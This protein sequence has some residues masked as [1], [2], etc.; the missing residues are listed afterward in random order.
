MPPDTKHLV[1][2]WNPGDSFEPATIAA[3]ADILVKFPTDRPHVWW[4]KLSKTGRLGI[5][6]ADVLAIQEQIR[7]GE[8]THLYLY[9]P[10]RAKPCVHVGKLEWVQEGNPGEP[11][12]VPTYYSRLA[13]PIPFW[14]R[15]SDIRELTT[16]HL[17]YLQTSPGR[18]Y[19]P[20]AANAYPLVVNS[21]ASTVLFDYSHPGATKWHLLQRLHQPTG[22][23]GDIDP[24]LVFVLMPFDPVFTDVWHLGIKSTVEKLGLTCKRANEFLHSRDIMEEIRENIR[25]SRLIIADMTTSN[26]NVFYELGYAHALQ[27]EVLLIT[28]DR[29]SVPFDLRGVNN[30]GYTHANDLVALLPT[31]IKSALDV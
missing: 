26:P 10:D 6:S 21:V 7:R 19:D 25:R 16:E 22:V 4:G 30:I 9:C 17:Q 18:P 31:Y 5:T 20:V 15:L 29:S 3:H 27:K 12:R 11:D 2:K 23:A 13:Y 28:R 24:R 1:V 14:F 8:E